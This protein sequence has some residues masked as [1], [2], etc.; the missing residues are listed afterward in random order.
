MDQK[1]LLVAICFAHKGLLN[2][3]SLPFYP[4]SPKQIIVLGSS[5]NVSVCLCVSRLIS[6]FPNRNNIKNS[7]TPLSPP[8]EEHLRKKKKSGMLSTCLVLM[9]LF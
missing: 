9:G 3:I 8:R 1:L 6:L 4:C 7:P 2:K 5:A